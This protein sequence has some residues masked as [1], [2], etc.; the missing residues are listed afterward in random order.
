[1]ELRHLRYFV[2]VAEELHFGRAA[3]R[4]HMAQ[5]P[6]S[7]QIRQLEEELGVTLLDRGKRRVDLTPAGRTFL[8]EARRVLV[9][10][11]RAVRAAQRTER[12]EIGP[13]ALGFVPAA[14]LELL[15]R[16]LRLCSARHP[17]FELELHPMTRCQ[18]VDA[19][20]SGRIQVGVVF[21]PFDGGGLT[22]EPLSREPLV[23]VLPAGH[24]LARRERVR[25]LDLQDDPM[26]SF[27]RARR[28]GDH[29]TLSACRRAGFEPRM[30]Y[31]TD[32]IETNLA[33]V[34]A[35]LGVSL[36]PA[37][38]KNL[39]RSGVVYRPLV[40]PAPQV[41]MAVAYPREAPSPAVATFLHVLREAARGRPRWPRPVG[42]ARLG[43]ESAEP[44]PSYSA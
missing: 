10:S 44:A 41:E 17:H 12:G 43:S 42:A 23:A 19:L 15:P 33:L 8:A 24:R 21:L 29:M 26:I 11:E 4:L 6:L 14:D 38:I 13:L 2:A 37:S 9:Q 7:R 25:M 28:D 16:A 22:I 32:R 35:G 40:P 3:A 27:P 20:R 5:P 36:M 31:A 39:R 34:A 18:Q 1:M 30:S